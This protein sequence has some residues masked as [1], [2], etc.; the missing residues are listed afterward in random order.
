[1]GSSLSTAYELLNYSKIL[2]SFCAKMQKGK[3]IWSGVKIFR[4]DIS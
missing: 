3:T 2:R 1:M 4:T